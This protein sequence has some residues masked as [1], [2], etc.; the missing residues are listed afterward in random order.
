[1]A[2]TTLPRISGGD[3]IGKRRRRRIFPSVVLHKH[4]CRPALLF[5][6]LAPQVSGSLVREVECLPPLPVC[7]KKGRRDRSSSKLSRSRPRPK[8]KGRKMDSAP[9]IGRVASRWPPRSNRGVEGPTGCPVYR[10]LHCRGSARHCRHPPIH[11]EYTSMLLGVHTIWGSA[12][13]PTATYFCTSSPCLS[14]R[15]PGRC[16]DGGCAAHHPACGERRA[17]SRVDATVPGCS[18]APRPPW[19]P[20]GLADRSLPWRPSAHPQRQWVSAT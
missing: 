20:A 15:N 8:E 5:S 12:S 7:R 16:D 3:P 9:R 4:G 14:E 11:A 18:P 6:A 17:S 2:L 13:A 19:D 1:M 10:L